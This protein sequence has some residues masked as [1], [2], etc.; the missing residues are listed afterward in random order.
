M[1][2]AVI[3]CRV[4]TDEEIQLNALES[5]VKEAGRPSGK[6]AGDVRRFTLALWNFG[7]RNC[8]SEFFFR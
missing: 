8:Q 4:S 5:Q 1:G 7:L 2:K 6:R 3:Y